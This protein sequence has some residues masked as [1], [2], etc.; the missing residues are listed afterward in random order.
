MKRGFFKVIICTMRRLEGFV[1][2]MRSRMSRHLAVWVGIA[3]ASMLMGCSVAAVPADGQ[4]SVPLVG[5]FRI[6][7]G[8]CNSATDAI[9]GS[10]FRLIFPKGN[11]HTGFFFQNATSGCFDKSFTTVSVGSQGGLLTGSY[12]PGPAPA[13][14]RN[15][16]ARA[17]AIIRPVAF[18]TGDL[19]LSTQVTDPQTRRSV[20]APSVTV[21]GSKLTGDLEAVSASW[22]KIHFN[23]GSPKP[24]GG[25]PGLTTPVS[26]RYNV[27]THK[28]VMNWTSLIVGGPFTGFIGEWHLAGIFIPPG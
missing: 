4:G 2:A 21:T 9:T 20:P 27:R 14:A 15:G 12:Q 26:G 28:F 22:K 17:R 18:A 19:S 1:L 7:E 24:G 13:F 5:L 16:D 3:S 10:Y 6:S 25:H 8:A 11:V 23:Q